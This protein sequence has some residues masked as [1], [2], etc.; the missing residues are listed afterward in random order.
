VLVEDAGELHPAHP[1]VVGLESRP[2]NIE[3]AGEIDL[4]TMVRQAL[5]TR[6]GR[7]VVA[8]V[9]RLATASYCRTA[10]ARCVPHRQSEPRLVPAASFRHRQ[11]SRISVGLAF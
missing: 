4:R 2:S 11:C 7:L 10:V 6:L 1:H 3:G 5:R 8:R 9:S